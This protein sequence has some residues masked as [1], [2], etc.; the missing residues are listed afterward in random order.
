[1]DESVFKVPNHYD[2][3]INHA[4]VNWCASIRHWINSLVTG[5]S[6]ALYL[7]CEDFVNIISI[8]LYNIE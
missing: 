7:C 1:M 6:I 3:A 4:L 5:Y 2:G 8:A